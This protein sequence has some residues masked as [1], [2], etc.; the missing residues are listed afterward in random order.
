MLGTLP[1]SI[2]THPGDTALGAATRWKEAPSFRALWVQ[3]SC[4]HKLEELGVLPVKL[5]MGEVETNLSPQENPL[6][7]EVTVGH[8]K[9]AVWS[10][11]FP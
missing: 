7:Q 5:A 2:D 3:T 4:G 6:P 10:F 1:D 8:R 11:N 9:L